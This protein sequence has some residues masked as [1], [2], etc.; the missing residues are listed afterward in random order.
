[1]KNRALLVFCAVAAVTLACESEECT[2]TQRCSG[3]TVELC[4]SGE[5]TPGEV[6]SGAN[7]C[8]DLTTGFSDC[9]IP[10][11]TGGKT[12]CDGTFTCVQG[13]KRICTNDSRQPGLSWMR[14]R[15]C[16]TGTCVGDGGQVE[17][18]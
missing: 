8:I 7:K 18:K 3:S 5:F 12:E 13:A 15:A 14:A 2:V 9:G 11:A 17:C 1:M 6:C 4:S 16:D 10:S